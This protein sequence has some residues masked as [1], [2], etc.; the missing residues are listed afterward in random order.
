MSFQVSATTLADIIA[1]NATTILIAA[2][3][4]TTAQALAIVE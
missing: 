3:T 2:E 4:G 1:K